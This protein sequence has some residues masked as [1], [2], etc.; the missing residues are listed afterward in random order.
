MIGVEFCFYFRADSLAQQILR[1][2]QNYYL[3]SIK[4]IEKRFF[5]LIGP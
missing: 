1:V 2:I 5:C 3:K 4:F